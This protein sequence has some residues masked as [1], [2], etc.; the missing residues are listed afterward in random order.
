M[1]TAMHVKCQDEM[2]IFTNR[3][4]AS[5]FPLSSPSND[6]SQKHNPTDEVESIQMHF[7]LDY[8]CQMNRPIDEPMIKSIKRF[9]ATLK[10][11][12]NK[13]SVKQSA[14]LKSSLRK[15]S[16]EDSSKLEAFS[17]EEDIVSVVWNGEMINMSELKNRDWLSGMLILCPL[18]DIYLRVMM[19]PP[20][21]TSLSV[22]PKRIL[23]ADH[24]IVARV[25]TQNDNP[26]M[27][28]YQWCRQSSSDEDSWTVISKSPISY[29][30]MAEDIGKPLKLICTPYRQDSDT[31]AGRSWVIDLGK[32]LPSSP[33]SAASI[34]LQSSNIID[35]HSDDSIRVITYNILA[36]CFATSDYA[37]FQL[38]SCIKDPMYLDI[39]YRMQ[40]VFFEL[41]TYNGDL[42][43]LQECDEKVYDLYLGPLFSLYGYHSNYAGKA[44]NNR[45]GCAIF[46]RKSIFSDAFFIRIS[47]GEYMDNLP[48]LQHIYSNRPEIHHLITK[49][50]GTIV[51]IAI[52][53]RKGSESCLVISNTHLFYHPHAAFLRLLQSYAIL[54]IL[55]QIKVDLMMISGSS[56]PN[57][58]IDW[59]EDA[60]AKSIY[61]Y[62]NDKSF[63]SQLKEVIRSSET[64]NVSIIMA[65]DLNSTPD[66]AS[67]E[68]L[69]R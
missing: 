52:C 31:I 8:L 49:K 53:V 11:K 61:R 47:L 51:Q 57:E 60:M 1:S 21:I 6:T 69:S 4:L 35:N 56:V 68:L 30:P 37:L 15:L 28:D 38:Y 67:I 17:E 19:N 41:M 33:V 3:S 54:H 18:Y 24:P 64:K 7:Y 29:T 39:E 5:S 20:V 42:I 10:K 26:G 16:S 44:G 50:L 66:A 45:H 23:L 12:S 13:K 14:K 25:T 55:S 58:L 46:A 62:C 22:F 32:V 27:L 34:R 36:D 9:Q 43:C 63:R 40:L 48:D 65:G 59:D 2:H